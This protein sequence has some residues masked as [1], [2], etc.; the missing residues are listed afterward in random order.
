[1]KKFILTLLL[2]SYIFAGICTAKNDAVCNR[3]VRLHILANS[4]SGF[5]QAVKINVKN[6]KTKKA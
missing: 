2:I 5:D 3:Y 1:M 6:G 4:N